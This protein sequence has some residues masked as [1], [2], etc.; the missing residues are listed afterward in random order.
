MLVQ[1]GNS[2]AAAEIIRAALE[3]LV[4]TLPITLPLFLSIAFIIFMLRTIAHLIK[5]GKKREIT[6]NL[7]TKKNDKILGKLE[8]ALDDDK[9]KSYTNSGGYALRKTLEK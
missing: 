3:Q 6:E 9:L 4:H 8:K 5:E 1:S 2:A 7:R